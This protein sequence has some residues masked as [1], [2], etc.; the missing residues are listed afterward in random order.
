ML[1]QM[2]DVNVLGPM[3]DLVPADEGSQTAPQSNSE[4]RRR[5]RVK[6]P[7]GPHEEQVEKEKKEK[8]EKKDRNEKKRKNGQEGKPKTKKQKV[9]RSRRRDLLHDDDS[10]EMGYDDEDEEPK[11][12]LQ[13]RLGINIA[14][15][16]LQ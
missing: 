10:G 4:E 12:L 2:E 15:V 1:D 6:G 5:K 11:L 14:M 7:P 3:V 16:I 8:K 9:S 13:R